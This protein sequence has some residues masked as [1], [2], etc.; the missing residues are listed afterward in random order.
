MAKQPKEPE[1]PKNMT[2]AQYHKW[3]MCER[4]VS[5]P[6]ED[7]AK[8]AVRRTKLNNGRSDDAN[9]A[10]YHCP[11]CAQWHTGHIQGEPKVMIIPKN[12]IEET[13][14]LVELVRE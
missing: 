5:H 2:S 6:S 14:K 12:S 13:I 3:R 8:K 4:K 7:K 1:Q 10:A 9:L 11:Y